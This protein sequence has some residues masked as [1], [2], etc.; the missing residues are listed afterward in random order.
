MG[1]VLADF[2]KP[3]HTDDPIIH[4][5]ET[6]LQSYD[7]KLRELRGVYYTPE[8]V[9]SY[10]VRSVDALLK[11]DFGLHD[12][13]ADTSMTTYER[14][15]EQGK[16]ERVTSPRVL[17]LDP[18]CGTGTF[19]Y[20]VIDHIR[21]GFQRSGMAGMWSSYVREHLLPRVFGFELLMAPYAVAHLKL[22]MQL[23]GLDLPEA[24]RH[25][26]AYDFKGA[27]RLGIYLTNTLEEAEKRW[28]G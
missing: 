1:A 7:P 24:Q 8:P 11:S 13:L 18:A 25:D 26:W 4:F 20:Y 22:G 19:L 15:N 10:I 9:V 27:E 23:A 5:Y 12:G 2:G 17:L 6:F 3:T 21:G 14:Q 28:A 16:T